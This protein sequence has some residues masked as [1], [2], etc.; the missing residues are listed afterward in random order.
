MQTGGFIFFKSPPY[1]LF[2]PVTSGPII[3]ACESMWPHRKAVCRQIHSTPHS[4]RKK[5]VPENGG[6]GVPRSSHNTR[7]VVKLAATLSHSSSSLLLEGLYS[8]GVPELL[9]FSSTLICGASSWK[10]QWWALHPNLAWSLAEPSAFF[11]S[12]Q[13]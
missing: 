4:H 1:S 13:S 7:P 5:A 3:N 8:C 11:S 6:Q 2:P 12:P 9:P 10:V